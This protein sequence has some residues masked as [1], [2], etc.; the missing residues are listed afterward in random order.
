M[1]VSITHL[2]MMN[3]GIDIVYA[4][5]VIVMLMVFIQNINVL[6]CI[7]EKRSLF[8]INLLHHPLALFISLGSILL[9]IVIS[10]IPLTAK[11]LKIILM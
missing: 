1:E 5:S 4:R 10:K 3:R 8:K 9:Q 6:N 11:I 7:S 2:Y